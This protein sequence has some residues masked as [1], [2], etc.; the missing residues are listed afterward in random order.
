MSTLTHQVRTFDPQTGL[1]FFFFRLRI[2]DPMPARVALH[3]SLLGHPYIPGYE[4]AG[5]ILAIGD[6][7]A[8]GGFSLDIGAKVF[9]FTRVRSL[10]YTNLLLHIPFIHIFPSHTQADT[11]FL[12]ALSF[13]LLC[14]FQFG[15]YAQFAVAKV[16]CVFP[17]PSGM[18]Y[19]EGASL[20]VNLATSFHSLF[21]TGLLQPGDRVLIHGAAGGVGQ[22]AVQMAKHAGCEVFAT[23]GGDAKLQSLRDT[24]GVDHTIN[25]RTHDFSSEVRRICGA[26]KGRCLDVIL[27]PIGGKQLKRDLK[28]LR[29]G[30]RIISYG[31]TAL[32][33]RSSFAGLIAT[34]PKVLSMV[35]FNGIGLLKKSRAVVGIN[36]LQIAI[37]RPDIFRTAVLKALELIMQGKIR[38][39]VSKQYD[40]RQ[41][42]IAQLD[43]EERRTTGKI[44]FTIPQPIDE[45]TDIDAMPMEP[46]V[47]VTEAFQPTPRSATASGSTSS[48]R[49]SSSSNSIVEISQ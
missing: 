32:S 3:Q 21:H 25:Y 17:L 8:A 19:A 31:A 15:G 46:P 23:A 29:S 39:V 38:T 42:G 40:W 20:P 10:S 2:S 7:A 26:P 48:T 45:N 27:D 14:F 5:T 30:G 34:I 18:S 4:V 36:I 35:T 6:G 44:V 41:V 49:S 16:E 9:A 33:G 1:E 11:F 13:A 24:Y 43:M 22:I 28:L 47:D 37:D 12:P